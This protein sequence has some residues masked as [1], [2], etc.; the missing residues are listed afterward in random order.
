MEGDINYT[1]FQQED[2]AFPLVMDGRRA[3]IRV[4]AHAE[5]AHQAKVCAVLHANL[6]LLG[7]T[8]QIHPKR[9]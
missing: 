3:E 7:V 1:P 6:I 2:W 8:G 9:S 4:A 5:T